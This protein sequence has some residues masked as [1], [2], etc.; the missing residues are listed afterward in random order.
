MSR[1][2]SPQCR[3]LGCPLL[4]P[5][6]EDIPR[7]HHEYPAGKSKAAKTAKPVASGQWA[8]GRSLSFSALPTAHCPLFL[9]PAEIFEETLGHVLGVLL[10]FLFLADGFD[11]VL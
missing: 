3:R 5:K 11:G 8:V 9:L 1:R 10:N 6:A 2:Q 4:L 7:V